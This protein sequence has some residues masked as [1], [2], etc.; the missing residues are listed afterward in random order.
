[1]KNNY[2]VILKND[3]SIHFYFY[4]FDDIF[5]ILIY[6]FEINS[7]ND[8]NEKFEKRRINIVYDSCLKANIDYFKEE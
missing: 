8:E 4:L 6:I 5:D 1:M 2:F 3:K 7:Y